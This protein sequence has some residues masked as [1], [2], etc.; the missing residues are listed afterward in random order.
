VLNLSDIQFMQAALIQAAHAA[1][2]DEVPVGAVVVKDGLIIGYGFNQPISNSDPTAHAEIIALR[3]AA[4]H[5]H[6]Y[7]LVGCELYATLEPCVMCAGAILSARIQRVIFGAPDL[8]AGA[9]GSVV[10]L[11]SEPRLN[12]HAA[13]T[14]GVC[15]V[16]SV[17]LLQSFFARKRK[18]I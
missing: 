4:Q 10:D 2:V 11:F 18:K 3:M 16:E 8:K 14:G 6:N 15:S 5:L 12:H 1:S 7:R 9:C 17:Q 13:I